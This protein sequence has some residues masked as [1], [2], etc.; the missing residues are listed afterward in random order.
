[1]IYQ[2]NEVNTNVEKMGGKF[3]NLRKSYIFSGMMFA[4]ALHYY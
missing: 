4:K 3:G 2:K 1:M